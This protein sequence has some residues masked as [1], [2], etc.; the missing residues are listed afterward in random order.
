MTVKNKASLALNGLA[1]GLFF[2]GSGVVLCLAGCASKAPV[3]TGQTESNR[4]QMCA[5]SCECALAQAGNGN[6]LPVRQLAWLDGDVQ[7]DYQPDRDVAEKKLKDAEASNPSAD[8][9]DKF[10]DYVATLDASGRSTKAEELLKKFL[11][12]HPKDGR[13]MF[14]M[15]AH[16]MRMK[17]LDLAK[18][19]FSQLDKSTT[20]NAKSLVYNNLGMLA[21]QDGNRTAALDY[22][23]RATKAGPP[24]PAPFVNLG[25]LYLQSHSYADAQEMFTRA[26]ELDGDFEDAVLG[27][28]SALEGQGKYDEAHSIYSAFISGHA[29]S[30]SVLFNDA[31]VLGNHLKQKEAAAQLM[32]RY[33]Q[34]GGKETAK[35]H[36]IIQSW[37]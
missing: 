26:H 37:R 32:L 35:A 9:P 3:T 21:L 30:M 27:L 8:D 28:G 6:M 5:E 22:F 25:A 20:F 12:M 14:L 18:W 31:V 29:D 16:Y 11:A 36:D 2:W 4:M 19:F 33:I 13:A 7:T 1:M 24:T 15:G 34:H 17:R 23:D 10:L